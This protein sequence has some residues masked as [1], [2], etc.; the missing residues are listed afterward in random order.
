[1]K[2]YVTERE[3]RDEIIGE[4]KQ[5]GM[6]GVGGEADEALA[7]SEEG[8]FLWYA[9]TEEEG[10]EETFGENCRG[11]MDLWQSVVGHSC[12]FEEGKILEAVGA[13]R[14]GAPL[15]PPWEA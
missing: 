9:L 8:T 6:D 15:S 7:F 4:G 3:G 11:L 5:E 12:S 13:V 2:V 1:M 10:D 14:R